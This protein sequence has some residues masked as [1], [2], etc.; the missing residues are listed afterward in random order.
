MLACEKRDKLLFVVVGI[1]GE[2]VWISVIQ[3]I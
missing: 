3:N 1:N 2:E